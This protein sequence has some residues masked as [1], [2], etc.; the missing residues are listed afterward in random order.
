LA[1]NIFEQQFSGSKVV[2]KIATRTFVGELSEVRYALFRE[3]ISTKVV[4]PWAK[5]VIEA[6]PITGGIS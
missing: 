1:A 2:G 6:L 4:E 5:E 3:L